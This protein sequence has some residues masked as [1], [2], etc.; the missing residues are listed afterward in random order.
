M[1]KTCFV[2]CFYFASVCFNLFGE[3]IE[4]KNFKEISQYIKAETLVLLDIDD[5]LL[6]PV[7]TLGT[8]VW[9]MHRL[10]Y[11]LQD[12]NDHTLALDKALAEWEAVRHLTNIKIVEE[13]SQDLI[14]EMQKNNIVVMGLTTQG[15]ALAT[16][17]VVQ[18]NSLDIDLSTTAPSHEDH[19]FM[20]GQNGV[21][22]RQG[23]LFTAGTSKGKALSK[24]LDIID[25]HPKHIVFINDKKKH[26]QDVEQSFVSKE[27]NFIGLRYSYSDQ[28]VGNFR[29]AVADIQWTYS[30]FDY[31][32][33]D[34][35]AFQ[36]LDLNLSSLNS[37]CREEE[38][39]Y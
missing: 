16:R 28:R 38:K 20:N 36:L 15:L 29:E 1:K 17:T 8:D 18:L 22:Y 19:Y 4:T 9:F 6:I 33:S 11:H 10:K 30:T 32:I 13:G 3:I 14:K 24:F 21:L 27:V 35:E 23:V 26:L 37:Q 7:Q 25:Y 34:E 31:L 2:I 12:K 5:T 39:S